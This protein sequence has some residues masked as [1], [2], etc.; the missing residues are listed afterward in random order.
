MLID[1]ACVGLFVRRKLSKEP[2]S[3][4]GQLPLLSIHLSE[5]PKTVLNLLPLSRR[6]V[7]E[8]RILAQETAALRRTH[9]H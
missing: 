1:P 5:P 6:Q 9:A 7:T 2:I 4:E 3:L 8:T